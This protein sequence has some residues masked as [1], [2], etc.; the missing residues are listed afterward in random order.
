MKLH[1]NATCTCMLIVV[2]NKC[3]K[4]STGILLFKKKI[5]SYVVTYNKYLTGNMVLTVNYR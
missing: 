2:G 3:L 4:R 1:Y 5:E